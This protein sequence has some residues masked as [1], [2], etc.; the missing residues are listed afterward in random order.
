MSHSFIINFED[1]QNRLRDTKWTVISILSE[2][3]QQCLIDTTLSI[4]A[5]IKTMEQWVQQ[6]KAAEHAIIIYGRNTDDWP[7][8]EKKRAKLRWL[9]FLDVFI[10]AGGLFEWLLLQDIYGRELFPTQGHV[11]DLLAYRPASRLG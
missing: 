3:D 11:L 7:A 4:D 8:L 2:K 1:V 10:Y 5:E 6:G 9:G